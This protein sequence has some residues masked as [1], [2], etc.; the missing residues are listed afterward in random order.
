MSRL[1]VPVLC[2]LVVAVLFGA[3]GTA[4]NVA[5][6]AREPAIEA[7]DELAAPAAARCAYCGR[8][9]SKRAVPPGKADPRGPQ[10]I[11]YTVRM[12]DGSSRVFQDA[13]PGSW[14]LGERLMVIDGTGPLY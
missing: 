13:L 8:I 4:L 7:P 6:M 10:M 12:S 9:E 5:R 14:R 2:A 1:F 3:A 11:E